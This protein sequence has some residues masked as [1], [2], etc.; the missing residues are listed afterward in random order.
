VK[1]RD[2]FA[3][4]SAIG[5]LT[6]V[7]A[8][9]WITF[10]FLPV[11]VDNF[12]HE[13][14]LSVERA[15]L[16]SSGEIAA[17]ALAA[18]LSAASIHR[19]DKRAMC[20]WGSILVIV[21]N[22]LSALVSD[23]V[24]L[25][26]SRLVVGSGL[27]LTVSAVTALPALSERKEKL[28]AFG[29]FGVCALA[30]VLIF[31]V[32]PVAE[33]WGY[34]GVYYLEIASSVITI[35]A[36]AALPRGI[37]TRD[38]IH[39]ASTP[40]SGAV[41]GILAAAVVF[42][43]VQTGLWALAGQAGALIGL[44]TSEVN[45]YLGISAIVGMGGPLIAIVLDARIGLLKPLLF[46]FASQ[47]VLG[48]LLYVGAG[49]GGFIVGVAF[50]TASAFF[51]TPYILAVAAGLDK[52]GRVASAAGA[53]MN[54][55]AIGGPFFAAALGEHYGYPSVAYGSAV[56]LAAGFAM[57]LRPTR[58]VDAQARASA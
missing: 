57:T 28:Y 54:F 49:R 20:V 18:I 1:S 19:R 26:V 14:G 48:L 37:S 5:A 31:S 7:T 52:L 22:I 41:I 8:Y 2:P 12:V 43:A 29:Q 56:L 21:G 44:S 45:Q 13:L 46:G 4:R 27:G 17:V 10:I 58:I 30:S 42:Y 24:M 53:M 23:W 40:V 39:T 9:A 6:Y 33:L 32:S 55:G 50:L 25:A 51:A 15:G 35:A 38:T 47:A 34:R 36:S 16:V 3:S 11:L